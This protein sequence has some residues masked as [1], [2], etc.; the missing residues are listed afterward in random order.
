MMYDLLSRAG[1]LVWG[2]WTVALVI[3]AGVWLSATNGWLQLRGLP[4]WWRTTAGTLLRRRVGGTEGVS[5]FQSTTAA[6]AGTL[7]TGN[8]VG[9]ASAIALGGPG[10]IF[11]MWIAA[12][13]GMMTAY[14]ENVLGIL[15]RRR[16][17]DGGWLGGPMLYMER[18]LGAKWLACCW[19]VLCSVAAFG[20]GNLTQIN[21]IASSAGSAWGCPTWLTGAVIAAAAA[22]AILGG[23]RA[24]VKVTEKLIPFMACAYLLACAAVLIMRADRIPAAFGSILSGVFTPAAAGGGFLGAMLVGVRRGVFT[25]EAGLGSSVLVHSSAEVD[26]PAIQGM[27][28]V[29]E[30]FADTILMCTVTALVL[31]TSGTPVGGQSGAAITAAAFSAVFGR[32][33]G[34]FVTVALL[35]FAFAT[36]VGWGCCGERAFS[37]IAGGKGSMVYRALYVLA[38]IPGAMLNVDAAWALSDL[39]NGLMA[40]P[41]IVAVLLLWRKVAKQTRDYRL[42]QRG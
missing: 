39:L 1:E 8:I 13:F 4:L 12:L 20:V 35:L 37:Y 17:A 15:Y 18:G 28:G 34:S 26:H 19:A 36:I 24:L 2:P 3:A 40:L 32:Y 14:S 6:L 31:L 7:G 11:W 9:V 21:S 41:N 33:S 27:W 23:V 38:I 16:A 30:V 42:R 22:P 5:S 29:F 25:N 10:A